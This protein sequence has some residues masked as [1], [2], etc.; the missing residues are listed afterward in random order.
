MKHDLRNWAEKHNSLNETW[1]TPS[2]LRT[3]TF[4]AVSLLIPSVRT[5]LL[6]TVGAVEQVVP[7]ASELV[8]QDDFA[9]RTVGHSLGGL[10][11]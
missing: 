4:Y 11:R 10:L 1:R 6:E 7:R 9:L 5:R 3:T 2:G 8:F